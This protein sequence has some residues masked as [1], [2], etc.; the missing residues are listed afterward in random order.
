MAVA[1][2][3]AIARAPGK[4][5]LFGEHAVAYQQPALGMALQRGVRVELRKGSGQL[6]TQLGE[7]LGPPSA[8]AVRP[9]ALVRAA[10]G[11][12]ADLLDV[13][14]AIDIPPVAG[15][16]SSAAIAVALLRA[17]AMLEGEDVGQGA[18]LERAVEIEN[19]AHGKSS[20]LDPA[21][22]IHQGLILF[23]KQPGLPK[24]RALR[25]RASFH[26]VV[27]VKGSHGGTAR[28]VAAVAQLRQSQPKLYGPAMNA[29]GACARTGTAALVSGDLEAAGRA[30]DLAHGVLSGLGLVGDAVE[31]AV[32]AARRAG[33]LGAKMSGAGGMGGAFYALAPDMISANV[34]REAL[35]SYDTL[36][37]VE[38]SA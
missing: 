21:I 27:G 25:P 11:E 18:L 22:V 20:G 14:I 10:L 16:G 28:P 1:P 36:S 8:E 6:R 30:I 13:D 23:R 5:I 4:L 29:L 17:R 26:L 19:L 15:L 34:I 33:A 12:R 31:G 9:D 3:I 35:R 32:R 24:V 7:G 2:S 37:W 38:T